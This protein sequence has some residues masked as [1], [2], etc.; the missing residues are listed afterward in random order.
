MRGKK[1]TY[2]GPL[3]ITEQLLHLSSIV[4]CCYCLLAPHTQSSCLFH[5]L[6]P[7]V[8]TWK[9]LPTLTFMATQCMASPNM[10][11]SS[12]AS[13][14]S[15]WNHKKAL[16]SSK[17]TSA[18][19]LGL[20]N[21]MPTPINS[22]VELKLHDAL[23]CLSLVFFRIFWLNLPWS[24]VVYVNVN[25]NI[26]EGHNTNSRVWANKCLLCTPLLWVASEFLPICNHTPQRDWVGMRHKTYI[27]T[28]SRVWASKC[29]LCTPLLWVASEFLPICNPSPERTAG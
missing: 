21:H 5:H 11:Q 4:F 10:L 24:A 9:E 16:A 29:L 15:N 22:L 14:K 13:D 27:H 26:V 2:Q 6:F 20:C 17:S 18:H 28:S 25:W 23:W 19:I 1:I 3:H 8:H 7:V 12:C